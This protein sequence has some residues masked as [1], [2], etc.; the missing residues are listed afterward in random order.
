MGPSGKWIDGICPDGSV[1]DAARLSL[2][3]RVPAVA[4]W[5]PLAAHHADQD[6][7][8]V[9][10]LRVSTR[11]AVAALRLYREWLPRKQARWVKRRLKRIRRAA[12]EARDLDVLAERMQRDYGE[13]AAAV[14]PKIAAER[15]AVQPAVVQVAERCRRDDRFVRKTGK[16]LD[17]IRPPNEDLA[18]TQSACFRDWA[19]EQLAKTAAPFF[20]ALPGDTADMAALHQFRIRAKALRYAMEL[21]APAFGPELRDELYP[22]AEQ[23]QERLGQINDHVAARDRLRA[24]AAASDAAQQKWLCELAESEATRFADDLREFHVWWTA[25]RVESLRT[26]LLP[27]AT[28]GSSQMNQ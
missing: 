26:G 13:R 10:R 27:Q 4:H 6:V 11:R 20:A 2:A 16:L 15:A 19:A 21:L 22:I 9:H 25:E 24:W 12:G 18:A 3:A 1:G 23:L 7:E 8:H 28:C 17:G 5:L 14:L